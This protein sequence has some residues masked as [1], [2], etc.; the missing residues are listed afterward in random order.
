MI[1]PRP[2]ARLAK[3]AYS[4]RPYD[5]DVGSFR[6]ILTDSPLGTALSIAGTD[7]FETFLTDVKALLPSWDSGL[8]C[9]VPSSFRDTVQAA[10]PEIQALAD[11]GRTPKV[12]IGHS[13]G[14]VLA[15]HLAAKMCLAGIAPTV[16]AAFAPPCA[17]F[18]HR[19]GNLLDDHGVALQLYRLGED[20]IPLVPPGGHQPAPLRQLGRAQSLLGD[21]A[22]DHI[23][24]ALDAAGGA[25]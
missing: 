14:G 12:L 16:V 7:D 2:Y 15:V 5:I 6:A 17:A 20:E 22:I 10:W 9:W 11:Y 23:I 1:D 21:H 24:A 19:L 3:A 25:L 18:D 8:G 4:H 13:L